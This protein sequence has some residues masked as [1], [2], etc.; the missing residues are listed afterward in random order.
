MAGDHP[1]AV[2]LTRMDP[3]SARDLQFSSGDDDGAMISATAIAL[4]IRAMAEIVKRFLRHGPIAN[5]ATEAA[6]C[7]NLGHPY[8]LFIVRSFEVAKPKPF[9]TRALRLRASRA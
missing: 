5:R 6:A 3:R 7:E 4:A 2:S 8:L 9:L 1:A